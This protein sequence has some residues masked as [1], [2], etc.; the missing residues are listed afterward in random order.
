M[1]VAD[2]LATVRYLNEALYMAAGGL[3]NA[4]ATNALQAVAS[5]IEDKLLD[6]RD[7]LDEVREE[8]Q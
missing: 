5:E 4:E 2:I 3:M 1:D 7:R 8:M 6:V